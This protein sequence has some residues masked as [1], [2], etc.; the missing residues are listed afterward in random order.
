MKTELL[1]ISELKE[2]ILCVGFYYAVGAFYY[3]S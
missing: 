1:W 3:N 2:A